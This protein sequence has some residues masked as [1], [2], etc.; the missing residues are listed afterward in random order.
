MEATETI[1][2]SGERRGWAWVLD[3]TWS[4]KEAIFYS[5]FT[6]NCTF[7]IILIVAKRWLRLGSEWVDFHVWSKKCRMVESRSKHENRW[8]R[9]YYLTQKL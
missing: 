1:S 8:P 3:R 6:Y 9:E 7:D 5:I 4:N 2:R